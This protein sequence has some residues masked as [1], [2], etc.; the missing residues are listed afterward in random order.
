VG[1]WF[2]V[3]F[4]VNTL[5]GSFSGVFMQKNALEQ[6]PLTLFDAVAWNV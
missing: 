1:D 3:T 2:L 6:N 4:F 5:V